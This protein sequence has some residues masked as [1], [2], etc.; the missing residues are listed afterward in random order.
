MDNLTHSLFALT[1]ARTP[2]SRAGQGTTAAL[3]L[4]SN[5]PDIDIV[6]AAG[7][8]ASYLTWHRGPSH[9]PLGA[10]GLGV[11]VAA[12]VWSVQWIRN[13]RSPPRPE[14]RAA[15]FMAL[16]G[17]AVLGVLCHILMDLPTSYGTRLL[18]PF[19]WHWF[20]TD[21]MPIIDVY[22]LV[23]LGSG[24]LVPM[25][26]GAPRRSSAALV[27]LLMAANYAVRAVAHDRALT[28]APRAFG[29]SLPAPCAAEPANR[30]GLAWWPRGSTR[31]AGS[32][33]S[34]IFRGS[35]GERCLLDLAAIPTFISP[36][37]WRIIA[38]LSNGYEIRD[39]GVFDS[40]L[41]A[42]GLLEDDDA[43]RRTTLWF[44]NQWNE[45][46]V[47][48]AETRLG[49]VFL[50]FSRFPAARS[51]VNDKTGETIVRWTDMRFVLARAASDQPAG[52]AAPFTA[53]V[54]FDRDGRVIEQRLGP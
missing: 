26:P 29:A 45:S 7:G 47:A 43:E 54:R 22:L 34:Q 23:I 9:G 46:V 6:T 28:L 51:F 8:G 13:R 50:G 30:S 25:R 3:L 15:S 35:S 4:A 49:R 19:D 11:L 42:S 44:P 12:I 2:L 5:V 38:Q 10:V 24:L 37:E 33:G 18:S 27:L 1:L 32:V 17:I 36:F 20:T 14:G 31:Y 41:R 52:R 40:K 21:W 48:A 39:L 16:V 53:T